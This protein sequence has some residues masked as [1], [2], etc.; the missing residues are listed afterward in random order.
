MQSEAISGRRER[1]AARPL[2][3]LLDCPPETRQLLN[4]AAQCIDFE[5]GAVAFRQSEICRGLYVVVSGQFVR[6]TERLA[7][8]IILGPARAGELVELAAAL[9]DCH[10]T[11]T[12]AALTSGAL[13]LLPLEALNQA[14]QSYPPLRMQLLGEL[15][16]EVSR[17]YFA[18]SNERIARVRRRG[19]DAAL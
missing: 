6:R 2:A 4:G 15:A 5:A 16:R 8:R 10:H 3:E 1:I 7:T 18:C 14:F 13:L 12:L 17:G 11:Y 19:P 9:G